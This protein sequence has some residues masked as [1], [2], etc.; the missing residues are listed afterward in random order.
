MSTNLLEEPAQAAKAAGLL[1]VSDE[2]PGIARKRSGKA[3]RY[4]DAE[5]KPVR[6]DETLARIKSLA[7]PP[8][9]VDVWICSS[10]RGHI[11]ATGRDEKGR[12][13]YRYHPRW[14]EVRDDAKYGRM[15]AFGLAL[16][17]IRK[18]TD[19]DL[20]LDGM[21]RRK[22]L[23]AVV[24]LLERSLIRVGNEE[25]ARTNKS[26]GLTTMRNRHVEVEGATIEFQFKGKSGV[27]HRISIR[28]RRLARVVA[29]CQDLPGQELFTYL[30]DD[31]EPQ[32]V[33]SADVNDYLREVSGADFTAKDFRT[34][35]GTVLAS[36]A[37]QEFEAFDSDAQA[38]RNVVQA[39]ERVAERL[40]NTPS[41]C[42]KCYVHPAVL[43]A[44]LEGSMLD[45]LRTRTDREMKK[46]IGDLKPEEAAVLALLQN[47]LAREDAG[48]K[49]A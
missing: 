6:D 12:K 11:Q 45:A 22:V 31:G 46:S 49:R 10:D 41:V 47:R 20:K 4:F 16:P 27:K 21:P 3:F 9:W 7:I 13:Q 8:A 15:T 19:A 33:G 5:G 34:W 17:Q 23:A 24:Q 26:F 36:L 42:R 1:Y 2:K 44:Y 30:D 40:G 39:V 35:A 38:K 48:R 18:A 28:D 29:R 43:D 14:R 25:Y 37:L 32:H